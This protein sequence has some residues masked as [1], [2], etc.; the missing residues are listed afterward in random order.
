MNSLTKV[1]YPIP[2]QVLR[3][4]QNLLQIQVHKTNPQM[5][6]S[7]EIHNMEVDVDYI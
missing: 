4:G 5:R 7:P 2:G 1:E 6:L 3:H